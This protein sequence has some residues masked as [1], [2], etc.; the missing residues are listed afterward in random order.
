MPAGMTPYGRIMQQQAIQQSALGRKVTIRHM[1]RYTY[2]APAILGPHLIRLC[3]R[4][5]HQDALLGFSIEIEPRPASLHW[6]TDPQ[7]NRVARAL[8][9]RSTRALLITVESHLA[10]P[11][12]NPF[13]FLIAPEA[14]FWPFTYDAIT[15]AELQPNLADLLGEGEGG[16]HVAA[17]IAEARA[18]P[19]P[20]LSFLTWLNS[21]MAARIG[22]QLRHEPGVLTPEQTLAG[23]HGSCRDIAFAFMAIL[24]RLGFAARFVSGYLL[25]D[26]GPMWLGPEDEVLESGLHAWVEVWLPGAG[27]IGFDPTS[28]LLAAEHHVVLAAAPHVASAMPVS[29]TAS[30]VE[31]SFEAKVA[32]SF[33]S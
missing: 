24:R 3:P 12:R 30:R 25:Q 19:G 21:E 27:W 17:L 22:Y 11:P 29:G 10:L 14:E 7:G 32:V 33:E 5:S 4:L 6:I 16:P 18:R 2:E 26:A 13:D 20:L 23:R 31:S 28:G 9:D 15:Q 8:F 1:T